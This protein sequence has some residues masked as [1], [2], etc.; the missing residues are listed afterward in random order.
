MRAIN[1][2]KGI[3]PG[4]GRCFGMWR[5]HPPGDAERLALLRLTVQLWKNISGALVPAPMLHRP[6][7]RATP[8]RTAPVCD[9]KPDRV[10]GP[11]YGHPVWIRIDRKPPVKLCPECYPDGR[12]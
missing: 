3:Y 4:H 6:G 1:L 10:P 8:E 9:G 11:R 7:Y 5:R 12:L 2:L